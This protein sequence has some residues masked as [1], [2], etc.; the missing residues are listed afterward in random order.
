M[1]VLLTS[2]A[3]LS[4]HD[5]PAKPIE[6]YN[7]IGLNDCPNELWVKLDEESLIKQYNSETVVINGPRFWVLNEIS[8]GG[9]TAKGEVADFGGIEMWLV[10]Q[11]ETKLWEGVVGEPCTKTMRFSAL[12]ATSTKLAIG[13]MS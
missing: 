9:K 7:T 13:C 5:C 10:A 2:A 11:I 12:Q 3:N 8:G 1:A 4:W 6:V